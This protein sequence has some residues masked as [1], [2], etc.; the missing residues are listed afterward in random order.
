MT[1]HRDLQKQLLLYSN[2]RIL[3]KSVLKRHKFSINFLKPFTNSIN[4]QDLTTSKGWIDTIPKLC[5]WVKERRI[6]VRRRTIRDVF[7]ILKHYAVK[8]NHDIYRFTHYV[9]SNLWDDIGDYQ[10]ETTD[11]LSDDNIRA[12]LNVSRLCSIGK[13]TLPLKYHQTNLSLRLANLTELAIS[14]SLDTASRPSELLTITTNIHDI[15]AGFIQRR[16]TKGSSKGKIVRSPISERTSILITSFINKYNVSEGS[17]LLN[18]SKSM[19]M[20]GTKTIFA[21]SGL[22]QTWMNLHR[23]RGYAASASVRGGSNSIELQSLGRW[24]DPGVP[25]RNYVD[26]I[27]KENLSQRAFNNLQSTYAEINLFDHSNLYP[28]AVTVHDGGEGGLDD[29]KSVRRLWGSNPRPLETT[30]TCAKKAALVND[31][32]Y[33]YLY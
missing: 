26:D 23:I 24:S 32:E 10:F 3:S 19:L 30:A 13:I 29:G 17:P 27:A 6:T 31:K 1:L 20:T 33:S 12:I 7:S 14:I 5:S 25:Q 9:R 21:H 15:Q 4:W 28:T 22:N 16:I 18:I 2:E 8:L 11:K